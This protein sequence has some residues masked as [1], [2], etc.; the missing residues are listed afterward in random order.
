MKFLGLGL[1]VGGPMVVQAAGL[2]AE[3]LEEVSLPTPHPRPSP[4]YPRS[5]RGKLGHTIGGLNT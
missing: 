1:E 2:R 5:L 4:K 3:G